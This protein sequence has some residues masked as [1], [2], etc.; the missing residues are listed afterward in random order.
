G[1][2]RGILETPN[3][4]HVIESPRIERDWLLCGKGLECMSNSFSAADLE[5][6]PLVERI[7]DMLSEAILSGEIPLGSKLKEQA[8]AAS[9]GV[10]RGPLREAIRHLEGRQLV[11][12]KPNHGPRVISLDISDIHSIFMIREALEGIA[13]RSAAERL[14]DAE[15]K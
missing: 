14:S 6:K 15:L 2:P 12:R 3:L 1:H 5:V 4:C 7:A 8:L 11:K 10:S 13:C 9:L